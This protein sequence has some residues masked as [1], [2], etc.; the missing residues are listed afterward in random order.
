MK[1]KIRVRYYNLFSHFYDDFVA[2]HSRDSGGK[3]RDYL[4]EKAGLERGDTALDICTGTGAILPNLSKRVEQEGMVIGLDFSRGMLNAARSKLATATGVFL[5]EADVT[6]LPFRS[7]AFS[8]ITCSHAF[9]ELKGDASDECLKEINRVLKK[10]K[11]FLMMEHD[12]PKNRFVRMLFYARIFLMG[13]KKALEILKDEERLFQKN[14]GRVEK[15][16]T[17]DG[18]SKIVACEK[19]E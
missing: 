10:G 3:L 6:N 8:G 13:R 18:R 17:E 19:E 1:S 2:L 15:W 16:G 11:R 4:A 14:F 12:I 5:V 7:D 9:Y